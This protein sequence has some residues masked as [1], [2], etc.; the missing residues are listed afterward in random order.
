MKKTILL[1][2]IFAAS[3]LAQTNV[4]YTWTVQASPSDAPV[5][6]KVTQDAGT[7]G[8]NVLFSIPAPN[9]SPTTLTGAVSSSAT[10]LPLASVTGIAVG[11]GICISSSSTTCA[12]TSNTSDVVSGGEVALVTAISG[13]N[14]TVTRASI[15]TAA[16]YSSGQGVTVVRSGSYS[17][18]AANIIRD[19]YASV[20]ANCAYGSASSATG[21]AAIATAQSTLR[22]NSQLPH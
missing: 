3:A 14:V 9:T 15:G 4:V 8:P 10:T 7:A 18:L 6:I 12:M 1:T 17:Q 5:P 13:N 21:C 20:I 2:L 11:N 19:F 16:A 22:G